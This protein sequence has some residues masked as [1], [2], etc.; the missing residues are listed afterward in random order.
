M[1]YRFVFGDRNIRVRFYDDF[2]LDSK[3]EFAEDFCVTETLSFRFQ[4]HDIAADLEEP[5]WFE[6]NTDPEG[7]ADNWLYGGDTVCLN[8]LLANR[9]IYKEACKIPY[10]TN[11]SSFFEARAFQRFVSP[12]FSGRPRRS[13]M[14]LIGSIALYVPFFAEP[15]EEDWDAPPSSSSAW[16]PH[17]PDGLQQLHIVIRR[18]DCE[19][20]MDTDPETS[21]EEW[22]DIYH[23]ND[24]F[25]FAKLNLQNVTVEVLLKWHCDKSD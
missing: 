3:D 11:I 10:S 17:G 15:T 4:K 6:M 2:S 19:G 20:G 12:K 14:K 7:A 25:V 9:Q 8:L 24:L 22:T 16:K 23:L 5:F 18:R 1:I 21:D 13:C